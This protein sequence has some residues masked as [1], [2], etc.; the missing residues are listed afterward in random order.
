M[1]LFELYHLWIAGI[2]GGLIALMLALGA[3]ARSW[4]RRRLA[5]S[6]VLDLSPFIPAGALRRRP[7]AN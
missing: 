2:A 4:V 3:L 7:P 5:R 1:T 6:R